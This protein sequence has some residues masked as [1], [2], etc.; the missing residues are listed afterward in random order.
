MPLEL[1]VVI[2]VCNEEACIAR[3]LASW[4]DMLARLGARYCIIVLDDGS[5]DGTASQLERFHDDPSFEILHHA[6][7]GHGPTILRGY[8]LA[9]A[10][11][12]WVFQTDS[13]GEISP[14]YFPEFWRRRDGHDAVLGIRQQRQRNVSRRITSAAARWSVFLLYG[15]GAQDVNV[16]YRLM[17]SSVLKGLIAGMPPDTLVP[18]IILSGALA[19]A[20]LP[21]LEI[22]VRCDGRRTGKASLARFRLWKFAI[23]SLLQVLSYRFAGR[24]GSP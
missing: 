13:D 3:V 5:R 9:L 10:R 1:A 2:P 7:V 23:R 18:N 24:Q 19:R 8:N 12:Q 22:P 20:A 15:R 11:A 21:V 14:D 4:R 6:N 16:P 17:R